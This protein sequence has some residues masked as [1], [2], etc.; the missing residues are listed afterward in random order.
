MPSLYPS[1]PGGEGVAGSVRWD[2]TVLSLLR[3]A[4]WASPARTI[5]FYDECSFRWCLVRR[6]TFRCQ[7]VAVLIRAARHE[8]SAE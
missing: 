2:T 1:L 7:V 5:I 3:L 4:V 6:T 8:T